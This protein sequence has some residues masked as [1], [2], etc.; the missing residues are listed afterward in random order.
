MSFMIDD[1]SDRDVGLEGL[2]PNTEPEDEDS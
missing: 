1:I 2:E